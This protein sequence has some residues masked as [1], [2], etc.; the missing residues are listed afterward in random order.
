MGD[1]TKSETE[2]EGPISECT[3]SGRGWCKAERIGNAGRKRGEGLNRSIKRPPKP[4]S[5]AAGA[6]W[7]GSGHPFRTV[8]DNYGY[9]SGAEASLTC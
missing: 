6:L 1:A 8:T 9:Q 7:T 4:V 3:V 2:E 5:L